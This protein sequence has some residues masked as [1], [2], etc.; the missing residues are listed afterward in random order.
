MNLQKNKEVQFSDL[1]LIPYSEAWACQEKLFA[2]LVSRKLA[3]RHVPPESAALTPNYL[4]MCEHPHVFTLGKSG[5]DDNLLADEKLLK[6]KEAEFFRINRGG[7]ITYH[8]PGMQVGYP[9]IDLENFFTDIHQYMRYLEEVIIRTLA[10]Y[11]IEGGRIPGKTGVWLNSNDPHLA[12]KI[13]AMGVR[14]SRWVTMHG[15]AFNVNCD[16]SYFDLI[17]PCGM[18]GV[19]VTSLERELGLKKP[20]HEINEKVK[21]HF[22]DVFEAVLL[23]TVP[24]LI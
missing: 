14:C 3:M 21:K 9:I 23:N 1:G 15:W 4:L 24:A 10:E 11:S 5:K 2:D 13:C 22:E 18:P 19:N 8:G 16:L 12:R 17:N 6:Q 7:D 20:L